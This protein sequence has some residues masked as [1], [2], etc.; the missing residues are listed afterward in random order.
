MHVRGHGSIHAS[1]ATRPVGGGSGLRSVMARTI[2]GRTHGIRNY[3]G[4]STALEAAVAAGE[5]ITSSTPSC[6]VSLNDIHNDLVVTDRYGY[7]TRQTQRQVTG[8]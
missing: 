1:V 8:A 2:E 4:S 6:A 3:H 5:N 7:T